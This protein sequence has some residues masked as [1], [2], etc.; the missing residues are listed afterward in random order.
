MYRYVFCAFLP[1]ALVGCG[2]ESLRDRN[3]LTDVNTKAD[4]DR[5][6]DVVV[7]TKILSDLEV[8]QRGYELDSVE[9]ASSE[10]VHAESGSA[11][12]SG[13]GLVGWTMINTLA[14][15]TQ[16]L[17]RDDSS[18]EG[19][20][21]GHAIPVDATSLSLVGGLTNK[22]VLNKTVKSLFGSTILS[23]DYKIE[24]RTQAKFQGH[25]QYIVDVRFVPLSLEIDPLYSIKVSSLSSEAA[26]VGT[27]KNVIA[28]IDASV[29][30]YLRGL[31]GGK[32]VSD[33]VSV[34]GDQ[35]KVDVKSKDF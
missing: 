8:S 28:M 19:K 3:E 32:M 9:S 35:S 12:E 24:A 7:T 34:R 26:N 5:I 25:G 27:E 18:I 4:G 22:V 33:E 10:H 16:V 23:I 31:G 17:L 15:V 1:L 14:G 11:T 2:S 20:S 21:L 13:V 30:F 6:L 29:S